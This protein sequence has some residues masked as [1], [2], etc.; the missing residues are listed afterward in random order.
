MDGGLWHY[1][2]GSV[3]DHTQEKEMQK[4]NMVV[5]RGLTNKAK[6]KRKDIPIRMQSYR[7][8]EDIP[9][10]MQSYKE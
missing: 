4:G 5:W 6:E 3:Q 10:R 1:T 8:K 9:I 7:E 2:G